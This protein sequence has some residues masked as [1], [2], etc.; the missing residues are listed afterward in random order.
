MKTFFSTSFLFFMKLQLRQS[1][2]VKNTFTKITKITDLGNLE[3]Y[4]IIIIINRIND[5][6]HDTCTCN[7][8]HQ[9]A[10]SLQTSHTLHL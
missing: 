6:L 1:C 5:M 3:L 2:V 8:I 4:C 7:Y 9:V 10:P